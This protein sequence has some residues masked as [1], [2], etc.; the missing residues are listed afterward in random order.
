MNMSSNFTQTRF[1]PSVENWDYYY[2]LVDNKPAVISVD[3]NL[4]DIVPDSS[5]P[6]LFYV[7]VKVKKPSEEGFPMP[8]ELVEHCQVEDSIIEC[9]MPNREA[10]FCGR[11]TTSGSRDLIFYVSNIERAEM[12][13]KVAMMHWDFKYDCGSKDD[14]EWDFYID[15]LFPNERELNAIYN[16]RYLAELRKLGDQNHEERPVTHTLYFPDETHRDTFIMKA[17]DEYYQVE[18]IE[19]QPSEAKHKWKTIISRTDSVDLPII[20]IQTLHLLDLA[21]QN[22][23]MYEG[24]VTTPVR[25]P[26]AI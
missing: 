21:N 23:G 10:V 5:L 18:K 13:T 11:V 7:S 26:D 2:C 12:L 25:M 15:F 24:W 8:A 6:Y 3:L 14:S 9:L 1:K 17:I 4:V 16:H 20:N 19:L 22:N